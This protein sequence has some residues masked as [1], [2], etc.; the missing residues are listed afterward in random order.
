M[1]TACWR[2]GR[3]RA[4]SS[5]SPEVADRHALAAGV[6][7]LAPRPGRV[8][9]CPAGRRGTR[10]GHPASTLTWTRSGW[11][12]TFRLARALPGQRVAVISC[13]ANISTATRRMA[14]YLGQIVEMPLAAPNGRGATTGSQWRPGSAHSSAE[15]RR[16]IPPNKRSPTQHT[17]FA[18]RTASRSALAALAWP[19]ARFLAV[20]VRSN[21][22]QLRRAPRF[23]L[24]NRIGA[25]RR[26]ADVG[27]G[28]GE[29]SHL[30][31]FRA[32][33]SASDGAVVG[34]IWETGAKISRTPR[35]RLHSRL[36][37][38]WLQACS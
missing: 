4:R 14:L 6:P 29:Y 5:S 31:S 2:T 20:A 3:Q 18:P 12:S 19:V 21:T 15:H 1:R 32:R 33:S 26:G 35:V 24:K 17:Q 13:G 11:C 16:A 30:E 38:S 23:Q 37:N 34:F 25:R 9:T 36:M 27:P 28:T 10:G 7:G 22:G 8:R